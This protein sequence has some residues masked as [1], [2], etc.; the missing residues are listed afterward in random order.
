[1][2]YLI[3]N[4]T[5][6]AA[7][8]YLFMASPDQ[9]FTS[10]IGKAPQMFDA[11]RTASRDSMPGDDPTAT[12][13]RALLEAVEPVVEQILSSSDG[14]VAA[15]VPAA[16]FGEPATPDDI[17]T[18]AAPV[19]LATDDARPVTIQDIESMIRGLIDARVTVG[20]DQDASADADSPETPAGDQAK[21]VQ[22]QPKHRPADRPS[23]GL[24]SSF[25]AADPSMPTKATP[26]GPHDARSGAVEISE[27]GS[28][29]PSAAPQ[30]MSD[31]EIAT[32]F[33]RLQQAARPNPAPSGATQPREIDAVGDGQVNGVPVEATAVTAAPTAPESPAFM[34]PGQRADS[35]AMMV[36][37]LQLM[38]LERTGG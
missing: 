38:Y 34:S 14:P 17:K 35:L 24:A 13:G 6:L 1:M 25:A 12:A 19:D 33:S 32:A 18:V 7:L 4:V 20:D 11:A 3:F 22:L 37:E 27:N 10:W 36:E 16:R 28:A 23:T 26:D 15:R 9:S 30:E 29:A 8:G 2:R 21:N 5:V 31:E